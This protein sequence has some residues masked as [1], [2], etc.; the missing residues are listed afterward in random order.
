[1]SYGAIGRGVNSGPAGDIFPLSGISATTGFLLITA[2]I[3]GSA[4]TA[5]TADGNAYDLPY[6][7]I[8][9]AGGSS[10]TVFANLGGN[11]AT[12]G[13]RQF[14]INSGAFTTAFSGD[15]MFT[16]SGTLAFWGTATAG[17]YVTGYV[18]RMLTSST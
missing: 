18:A 4:N 5:H 16:G 13:N 2:T 7:T 1:M 15:V 9:N 17:I 6:V 14:T 11:T 3:V 8:A 10:V 12:T